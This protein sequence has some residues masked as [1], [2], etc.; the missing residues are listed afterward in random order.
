MLASQRG[1][2]DGFSIKFYARGKTYE[3]PEALARRFITERNGKEVL[4]MQKQDSELIRS[5]AEGFAAVWKTEDTKEY[6]SF[7][8]WGMFQV[9]EQDKET[10][11]F[12]ETNKC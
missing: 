12:A 1:T 11:S 10:T 6:T 2:V 3:V 7:S 5:F 8:H 4:P 9:C